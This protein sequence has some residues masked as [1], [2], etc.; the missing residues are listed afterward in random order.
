M[1]QASHYSETET[2]LTGDPVV[3]AMAQELHQAG[4]TFDVLTHPGGS[5]KFDFMMRAN[6]EYRDRGGQDGGHIGA[7]PTAVLTVLSF[8]IDQEGGDQ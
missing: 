3:I 5:P 7:V 2:R 4:M 6:D 1:I 8:L